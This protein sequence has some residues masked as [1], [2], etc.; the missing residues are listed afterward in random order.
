MAGKKTKSNQTHFCNKL[1]KFDGCL[2]RDFI[3]LNQKKMD[4]KNSEPNEEPL[5]SDPEENLRMENEL[6]KLKLQAQFGALSSEGGN[7][8]PE[9]ENEFL[10]NVFAFE[11]N[12]G[13]YKPTKV[14]ELLGN[15][16]FQKSEE[17]DN[18]ALKRE[19]GRL[20]KLMQ[21]KSI[22]VGFIRERDDRF[23]YRFITEELFHHETDSGFPGMTTNFIYEEFHPD[24][25][26]DIKKRTD[27]FLGNWFRKEFN[28]YSWELNHEFILANQQTLTREQILKKIQALFDCYLEFRN[29]KVA[30]FEIKFELYDET[31]TGMGH[32]E[33]AVKY[34]AFLENGEVV[35]FEG[36][37][38]LYLSYE[39]G[40]WSIV[41][42]VFPGF[43]W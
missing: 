18:V 43:E 27:E 12:R 30:M 26:M 8:P 9:I 40:W 22:D 41:Y 37:F 21:E 16:H 6:L 29:C 2:E 28:E 4:N 31:Q 42:F 25:E 39:D 19:Y 35:H 5:S 13:D 14:V 36:P 17:L 23:K 32:S 34:D 20:E 38:K 10:K 11:Q 1:F 33:G 3:P 24:H 15:P 7:L